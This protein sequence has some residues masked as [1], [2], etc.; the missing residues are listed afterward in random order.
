MKLLLKFQEGGCRHRQADGFCSI[1][2]DAIRG[3]KLLPGLLLVGG[4]T[5][6]MGSEWPS[7]TGDGLEDYGSLSLSTAGWGGRY[8][9]KL[10]SALGW[11]VMRY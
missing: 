8:R 3:G 7:T 4:G 5:G 10:P 6:A 11:R 9:P 2:A 1:P